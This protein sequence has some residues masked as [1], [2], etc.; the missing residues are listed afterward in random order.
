MV[1]LNNVSHTPCVDGEG[2][3][4]KRRVICK[5]LVYLWELGSDLVGIT[6]I[7]GLRAVL[8][9]NREPPALCKTGLTIALY[10]CCATLVA[11]L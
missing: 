5:K 9:W 7:N 4:T 8:M 11:T 1:E 6:K 2:E 3:A 10:D